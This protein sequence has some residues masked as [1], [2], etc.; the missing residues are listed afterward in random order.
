MDWMVISRFTEGMDMMLPMTEYALL[1]A[2]I[3]LKLV[4]T[5]DIVNPLPYD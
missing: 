5:H 4:S 3:I 1:F 2:N